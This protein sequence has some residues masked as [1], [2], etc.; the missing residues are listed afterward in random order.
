MSVLY[1]TTHLFPSPPKETEMTL[2]E[3]ARGMN[4][5]ALVKIFDLYSHPIYNYALRLSNDPMLADYIVGDVFAKLLEQ[6]SA[7]KGPNKN[8]RSYLYEMAYHL[9]VDEARYANRGTPL[10]EAEVFLRPESQSTP[11]NVEDRLLYDAILRA[12]RNDLTEDQRHVVVLRFLE[13]FSLHETARITGKHV[14]N[15]KVIQNRAIAALRKA[16]ENQVVK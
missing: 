13:G 3:G 15:V 5:D 11:S 12:I 2:L 9:V 14:G 4:R 16:L 7:G 10:E 1:K 8:L 6:L